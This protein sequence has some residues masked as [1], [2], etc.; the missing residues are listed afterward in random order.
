M[1]RI[2]HLFRHPIKSHG[3][4]ALDEVVLETGKT[5]PYDRRWAVTNDKARIDGTVWAKCANFTRGAAHPALMA[6]KVVVGDD[7]TLT[8]SHPDRKDFTFQPDDERQLTGFL[9]WVKPLMDTDRALPIN[10]VRVPERGMTDTPFP[11]I[12]INSHISLKSLGDQ[13]GQD[14]SPLRFRGNVWINDLPAWDEFNWLGKTL[15]LGEAT[16]KVEERIG[17][18]KATMANPTTGIR[19]A[20]TLAALRTGWGHTDFGIYVTVAQGGIVRVGDELKVIE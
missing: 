19:D 20:D 2:T 16:L 10:I 1:P 4:E 18:C 11:S 5:L 17:R 6:I 3:V 8:L 13:M 12:S 7:D 15:Q 9:A 14:L